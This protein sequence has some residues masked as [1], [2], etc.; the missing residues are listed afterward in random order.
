MHGLGPRSSVQR[1]RIRA[2]Q[3][4]FEPIYR[5][6]TPRSLEERL[7]SARDRRDR[8]AEGRDPATNPAV[9]ARAAALSQVISEKE[10]FLRI[11]SGNST[12][13]RRNAVLAWRRLMRAKRE[14]RQAMEPTAGAAQAEG[15]D[16][17][18][19]TAK[20]P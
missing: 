3:G 8:E 5:D 10:L 9:A 14:Q 16:A 15:T 7:A 17:S 11:F 13:S 2:R 18:P 6:Y 19:I 1:Q 4:A 12:M 20:S